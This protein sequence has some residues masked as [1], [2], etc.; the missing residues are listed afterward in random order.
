MGAERDYSKERMIFIRLGILFFMLSVIG[1]LALRGSPYLAEVSWMPRWLGEWSDRHGVLRNIPAFT[2]LYLVTVGCLGWRFRH[3]ALI[4]TL[5][6][7]AGFEIVQ[8][9]LPSRIFGWDDILASWGGVIIGYL[10]AYAVNTL[11]FASSSKSKN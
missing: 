11:M 3:H 4:G 6:V 7:A 9:W 10:L 5:I 8:I 1:F 2:V